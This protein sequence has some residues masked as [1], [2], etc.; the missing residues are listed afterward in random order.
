MSTVQLIFVAALKLI[1][2]DKIS[3]SVTTLCKPEIF[4]VQKSCYLNICERKKDAN[5]IVT[6][7]ISL[8]ELGRNEVIFSPARLTALAASQRLTTVAQSALRSTYVNS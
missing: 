8:Q 7:K 6:I 2:A 4:R 1:A 5:E 3:F